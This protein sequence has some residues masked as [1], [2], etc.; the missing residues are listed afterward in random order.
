MS[1]EPGFGFRLPPA[2]SASVPPEARFAGS[3]G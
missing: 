2:R 3:N 1:T